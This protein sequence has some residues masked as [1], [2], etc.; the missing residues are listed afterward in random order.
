[1][2]LVAATPQA[3]TAIWRLL[4]SLDLVRS[5][6]HRFAAVDEPLVY[7]VNEPRM[8]GTRMS[9]A[10]WLRILDLPAALSARRYASEV[11]VV[12]EVTDELQPANAGRWRL[13]G[14]PSSARCVAT[15]DAADLRC[16]IRALGSAYLGGGSLVAFADSGQITEVRPGALAATATAFGW[17]RSPS[18]T[19]PF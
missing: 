2:E 14:S 1:M 5:A 15:A 18:V 8:L 3:Y 6:T 19:E 17:H 4:L 7:L 10:L 11:D 12:L 9:D 13:T 16:D